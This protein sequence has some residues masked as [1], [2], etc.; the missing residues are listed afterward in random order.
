MSV[1]KCYFDK[2]VVQASRVCDDLVRI[3][4]YD[5]KGNE[6]ITWEK[7]DYSTFQKSNGVVE[8]WSLDSLL[9]A[10]INPDFGI[11]TGF[12][13]RLDGLGELQSATARFNEL[14]DSDK[15]SFLENGI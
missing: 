14:F 5:E 6:F 15:D 13:T 4:N 10:G 8:D 11:R 3:V 1:L 2:S 9:K 12:N 7:F